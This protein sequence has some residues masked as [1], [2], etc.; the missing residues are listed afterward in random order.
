[1]PS[2]QY[3]VVTVVIAVIAAAVSFFAIEKSSFNNT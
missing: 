1:M 3:V 2:W